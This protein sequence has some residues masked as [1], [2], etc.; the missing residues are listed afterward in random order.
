M[1]D[2]HGTI[3]LIRTLVRDQGFSLELND[4]GVAKTNDKVISVPRPD[5][6]WGSDEWDRW[7]ASVFHECG[8]HRSGADAW[9]LLEREQETGLTELEFFVWNALEDTR[10]EKLEHGEYYGRDAIMERAVRSHIVNLNQ[11]TPP[12][13][14]GQVAKLALEYTV[15]CRSDYYPS[16]AGLI[17]F[18]ESRMTSTERDTYSV[19]QKLEHRIRGMQTAQ[20]ALD[21]MREII[22]DSGVKDDTEQM[23]KPSSGA[24]SEGKGENG[25]ESQDLSELAE[26]LPDNHAVDSPGNPKNMPGHKENP[27]P[28]AKGGQ[29][30]DY[31][32]GEEYRE[33]NLV[34]PYPNRFEDISEGTGSLAKQVRRLLQIRSVTHYE[35]GHRSGRLGR[36]LHRY[37]IDS[38]NLFRKQ[39]Q[40]VTINTAVTLLV[41]SSGSMAGKKYTTAAEAAV[42]LYSA[43]KPVG[44]DVEILAFTDLRPDKHTICELVK[45]GQ[46]PSV[47]QVAD[48]L[49][50]WTASGGNDDFNAILYSYHRLVQQQAQKK[51]LIVLS[52]GCPSGC[53]N[54]E[55][56][57]VQACKNIV[58]RIQD[59]G[60]KVYGIGIQDRSVNQIYSNRTVI[61]RAQE[62]PD[63]LMEVI[64]TVVI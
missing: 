35:D 52:D 7:M 40:S 13:P 29:G 23:P 32:A 45:F 61:Q 51:V 9:P 8:H 1:R 31:G 43:I 36:K 25:Y 54:W 33:V 49:S 12:T 27:D 59:S 30:R 4:A 15:M 44:C 26:S 10:M 63:K 34:Q 28:D 58:K 17:S 41:D 24:G 20:D 53:F 46:R 3:S 11:N 57:G 5:T 37:A 6:S 47:K 22:K 18:N 62:L 42:Q 39:E 48:R 21:I 14:E 60:V 50:R 19:L 55:N 38:P 64:K 2:V 56:N 16:I